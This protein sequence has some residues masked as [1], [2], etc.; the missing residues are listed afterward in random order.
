MINKLKI[1]DI[2]S[3]KHS[4]GDRGYFLIN[5][6]VE[7]NIS[8]INYAFEFLTFFNYSK[9][10]A[11]CFLN[12]KLMKK[13]VQ[14]KDFE[15]QLYKIKEKFMNKYLIATSEQSICAKIENTK[16]HISELPKK[17]TCYSEC[18]RKEVGSHGKDTRGIFRVHQFEKI[19][20]FILSQ[21]EQYNS[22]N[23]FINL[24][25]ITEKFY[26]LFS[27]AYQIVLLSSN[28]INQTSFLKF[29]IETWF[30]GSKTFRELVSCS[31]CKNFQSSGLS[32]KT[33]CKKKC[34]SLINT[35]NSTLIATERFICNILE[36]YQISSGFKIPKNLEQFVGG[37]RT[38]PYKC[39]F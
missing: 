22:S 18:F 9:M 17:I 5:E 33:V 29:D 26:K 24:M 19:E 16:H 30:P 8:L 34:F 23:N 7:L 12:K 20:Q 27:L 39:F 32:F 10:W 21:S 3:A 31:N 13:C 25:E 28:D 1:V 11:P 6:G 4:I 38:I 35:F 14:L 37:S 36:E 15:E 2:R